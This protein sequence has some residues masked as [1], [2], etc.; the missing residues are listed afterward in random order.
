[1]T[2]KLPYGRQNVTEA[3][4]AAVS[5]ALRATMITQGPRV[6]EFEEALAN[7]VGAQFAVAFNSGT[8]ALHAAYFAAGV[9]EGAEII[10]SPIT[11]VAT[12]NASYYLGGRV[13]FGDIDPRNVLID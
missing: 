8:A 3:D 11:F 2:S 10:T 1:M 4:V 12:A 13:Q 7:A 5:A 9:G 6:G